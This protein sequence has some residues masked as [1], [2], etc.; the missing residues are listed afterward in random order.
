MNGG[1]RFRYQLE[2]LLRKREAESDQL[3]HEQTEAQL[4]V[5]NGE[6][7][8][9]TVESAI[10]HTET[11]LRLLGREGAAIDPDAQTR[12]RAYL[13]MLCVDRE[14]K[15]EKLESLRREYDDIGVR[16][17]TVREGV[18]ALEKH[19]DG[20]RADFDADWRRRD[21]AT[22]DELWLMRRPAKWQ[23]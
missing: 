2:S 1:R 3:R 11:R 6:R 9:K 18:K 23:S 15:R 5:D 12:L 14:K 19:R 21:Q 22:A 16:L 10:G 7:D 8:L 4:R 17:R 13:K 20:R